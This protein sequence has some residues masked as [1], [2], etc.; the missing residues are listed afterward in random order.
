MNP[1]EYFF[2]IDLVV[3]AIET[4][5]FVCDFGTKGESGRWSLVKE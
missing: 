2:F 4:A 5:N 3:L 1:F